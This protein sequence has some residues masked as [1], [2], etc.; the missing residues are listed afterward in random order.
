MNLSLNELESSFVKEV[1]TVCHLKQK[2]STTD[3]SIEKRIPQTEEN[4]E[5]C[6]SKTLNVS[7]GLAKKRTMGTK[8]ET[9]T[10]KTSPIGQISTI[11]I[12][13]EKGAA[14]Q[15]K[16]NHPIPINNVASQT[17]TNQ[18]QSLRNLAN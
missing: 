6:N 8:K 10:M 18:S 12:L 11:K 1:V 2:L 5:V 17:E 13:K 14:R 9:K 4:R 7:D 15:T 3:T 16:R